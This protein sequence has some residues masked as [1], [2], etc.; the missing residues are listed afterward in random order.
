LSQS[1]PT[2]PQS[3]PTQKKT[4]IELGE[5]E[6]R[7][8]SWGKSGKKIFLHDIKKLS[9]GLRSDTFERFE[10]QIMNK[11][12]IQPNQCLS[13]HTRD[14]TLDVVFNSANEARDFKRYLETY[15]P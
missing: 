15:L 11:G 2:N 10:R 9:I 13:V 5:G 14:R 12:V 6:N 1:I 4:K 3:L 8:L 7:T